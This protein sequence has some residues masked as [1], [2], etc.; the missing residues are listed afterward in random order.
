VFGTYSG[1]ER[2]VDRAVRKLEKMVEK[3]FPK[4]NLISPGLSI[5][6]NGIPGPLAEG[7]LPKCV[8]FGKKIVGQIRSQ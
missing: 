3:K 4:L 6:V 1:R 8:D 7:E 2:T 5:R